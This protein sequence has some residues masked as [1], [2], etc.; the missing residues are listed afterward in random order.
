MRSGQK[1]GVSAD[2]RV[3]ASTIVPPVRARPTACASAAGALAV[4]STTTSACSPVAARNAFTGSSVRDVDGEVGTERAGERE[5]LG[6]PRTGAGHHHERSAGLLRRRARGQAAHAGSED[7][8]DR[9]GRRLGHR[10]SPPDAGTER[11]EQRGDDRV[12]TLRHWEKHRVGTEVLILGIAAPQAGVVGDG[13][14]AVHVPHAVPPA[15]AVETRAQRSHSR[16]DWKTS[17]ATRS[18]TFTPHRSA[19][20]SPTAS[21]TPIDSCPGTNASLPAARR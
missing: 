11:V 7:G 8:D 13:H 12:E 3:P 19:A 15:P 2:P 6:V 20:R 10:D 5:P 9:S 21:I 14:E 16:H 18:P 17:T 1:P 4:T